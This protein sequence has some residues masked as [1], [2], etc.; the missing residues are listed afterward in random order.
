MPRS[1]V[2]ATVAMLGLIAGCGSYGTDGTS[3]P[4]VDPPPPETLP[5]ETPPTAPVFLVAGADPAPSPDGTR[6][7]FAQAEGGVAMLTLATGNVAPFF[8]A[9]SEPAWNRTGSLIAIAG[10]GGSVGVVDATSGELRKVF[11]LAG[12]GGQPD[13]APNGGD[14][15][16]TRRQPSGIGLLAYPGGTLATL[17]CADPDGS[18]CA[19]EGPSYSPDGLWIAFEDGTRLLKVR[20]SGGQAVVVV[21]GQVPGVANPAWSPDGR[22]I[23]FAVPN[24]EASASEVWVASA[25][26]AAQGLWQVTDGPAVWKDHPA[27]SPGAK[28]IYYE[29]S[30]VAGKRIYATGRGGGR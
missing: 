4:V 17:A 25:D 24:A 21:D 19:G 6:L 20:R 9:G 26:G 30:E 13:W 28:I 16:L 18:E 14:L 12:A 27:W 23:A 5:P 29:Q 7:A 2:W 15:A 8:A 3:P 11:T 1:S 10:G 22:W